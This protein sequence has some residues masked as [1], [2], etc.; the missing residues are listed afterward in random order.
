MGKAKYWYGF[1]A[2]NPL[3][4]IVVRG[5][6]DTSDEAQSDRSDS[7]YLDCRVS[8]VLVAETEKE[9]LD[10]IEKFI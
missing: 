2:I 10:K 8:I 7:K 1:Q 4:N 3:G 5:P 9:A 6:F